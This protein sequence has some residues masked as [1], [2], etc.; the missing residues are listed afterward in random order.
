[1]GRRRLHRGALDDVEVKGAQGTSE[2]RMGEMKE[3][4]LRGDRYT[5]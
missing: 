1:M 5:I 3:R 4:M 2:P